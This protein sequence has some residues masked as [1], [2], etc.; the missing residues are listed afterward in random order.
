VTIPKTADTG[1]ILLVDDDVH[2][3]SSYE[4]TLRYGGMPPTIPC[5]DPTRVAEFLERYHVI[6]VI[7]DLCM[8]DVSGEEVLAGIRKR[9]P[10]LPVIV[11]TGEGA[12]ETAVRLMRQGAGDYLVKPVDRKRLL[13]AVAQGLSASAASAVRDSLVTPPGNQETTPLPG[14]PER[15]KRGMVASLRGSDGYAAPHMVGRSAVMQEVMATIA[16]VAPSH[17]AVLITGETG[18]GK[19]LAARAVHAASGLAGPFVAVNAAGLDDALFADTL[20]GHAKAAFTGAGAARPGLVEKAAGGSLFLDEIGDLGQASQVKLL[21]LLQEKEY[22]PLGSDVV[23]RC[24]ARIIVATNLTL[25]ALLD[26]TR[27][28]LDLFYRL[29]T[30]HMHLPVLR[31]RLDDL[32]ELVEHFIVRAAESLGREPAAV[33]PG[34]LDR[35]AGY[36]FPGNLRE[37]EA[38]VHDALARAG[39]GPLSLEPFETWMG[40][41]RPAPTPPAADAV[42][43]PRYPGKS[44]MPTL[45]EAEELLIAEALRRADGNQA[46]AAAFLGITR[47]ALNR[48][49]LFQAKSG[50]N[51]A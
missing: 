37:L 48:R 15:G 17:Q 38:M 42:R 35:L 43:F 6:L 23:K 18:V 3:L 27:F 41:R 1:V 24:Q 7:L 34:L 31:D 44:P 8:P 39:D 5:P 9:H 25:D 10:H 45:K 12:V 29:R 19:E 22:Y 50:K 26:P 11:I 32:P 4:K 40:R 30:H 33:P 36:A 47:Q 49:L 51:V 2:I 21:R 13:D 16:A 14:L 20:F 46:Q 28:R